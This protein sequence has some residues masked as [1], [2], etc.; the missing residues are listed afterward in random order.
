MFGYLYS[1]FEDETD[2]I[3]HSLAVNINDL[4][5]KREVLQWYIEMNA[6]GTPHSEEEIARVKK[7]LE[8][9]KN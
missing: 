3:R 4:K 9:C 6:G 2:I 5:T 7:L 1:E 8:E